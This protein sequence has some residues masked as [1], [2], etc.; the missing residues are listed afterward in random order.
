M[1][2]ISTI[3]HL[4]FS[5]IAK[6][7]AAPAVWCVSYLYGV[8]GDAGPA[9]WRGTATESAVDMAL[10]TPDATEDALIARAAAT[11]EQNA[12]GEASEDIEKERKALPDFV[13]QAAALLKPLGQP[14]ARQL[15]IEA[16]FDG[17]PLPIVGYVDYLWADTLTDLKTTWRM[18]AEPRP[19]HVAQGGLY[20]RETKKAPSLAYVTPKKAEMKPIAEDQWRAELAHLERA[21]RSLCNALARFD[22]P[23]DMAMVYAPDFSSFYWDDATKAKAMEIWA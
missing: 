4:S 20:A 9:A 7:R 8:K 22:T 18:P 23:R 14:T 2:L 1:S 15:R 13:R 19:D 5:S 16:R 3:S 21:A 6:F 10:F 11:F 17:V 12:Q